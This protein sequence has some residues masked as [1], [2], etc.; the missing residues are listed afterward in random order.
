[1]TSVSDEPKKMGRPPVYPFNTM[2]IG[3]TYTVHAPTSKDAKRVHRAAS[4]YS[5]RHEKGFRGRMDR[6]TRMITFVRVR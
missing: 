1:M 5:D 4:N 6:K 3:D 2:E